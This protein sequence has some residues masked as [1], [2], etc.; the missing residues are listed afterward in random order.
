MLVE[1]VESEKLGDQITFE[2]CQRLTRSVGDGIYNIT[3]RHKNEKSIAETSITIQQQ[4]QQHVALPQQII[5]AQ[6]FAFPQTYTLP[7][8]FEY[9]TYTLLALFSRNLGKF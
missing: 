9:V 2:R 3:K 4:Q 8:Q 5:Q 1:R 6:T 7:Q